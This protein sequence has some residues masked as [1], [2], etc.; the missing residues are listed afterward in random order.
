MPACAAEQSRAEQ[1]RAE[2]SRAEVIQPSSLFARRTVKPTNVPTPSTD[3][4]N[5]NG[6]LCS[7]KKYVSP[8]F[9][10]MPEKWEEKVVLFRNMSLTLLNNEAILYIDDVRVR[11]TSLRGSSNAVPARSP[12]ARNTQIK[13]KP[14][15][16]EVDTTYSW[17]MPRGVD[18]GVLCASVPASLSRTQSEFGLAWANE[19]STSKQAS[20]CSP[21]S[22][23]AQAAC[24]FAQQARVSNF[25]LKQQLSLSCIKDASSRP[26]F[27]SADS[28]NYIHADMG[29]SV[30]VP[31]FF[32]F[33]KH[34]LVVDFSTD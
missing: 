7:K 29:I 30:P 34:N 24:C 6:I 11:H 2:Q 13:D 15:M 16:I 33:G 26:D 12:R 14:E 27:R 8:H 3:V 17:Q 1:S 25:S 20:K 4:R 5:D 32:V 21:P 9:L 18:A 22:A 10:Y 28:F 19:M 31:A 23:D